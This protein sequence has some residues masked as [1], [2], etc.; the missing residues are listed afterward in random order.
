MPYIFFT[1][2]LVGAYYLPT[3]SEKNDRAHVDCWIGGQMTRLELLDALDAEITE[4]A[5]ADSPIFVSAL[6]DY[7]RR[8][9]SDH[10]WALRQLRKGQREPDPNGG[11]PEGGTPGAGTSYAEQA[12]A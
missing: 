3:M 6:T 9:T 12:A 4:A 1:G 7:L 5:L 10:A 2:C 8:W 11:P